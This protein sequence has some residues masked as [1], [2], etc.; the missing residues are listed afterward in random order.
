MKLLSEAEFAELRIGAELIESDGH[1]EKVLR[2]PDGSYIKIFRRKSWFS[3][4]MLIPP[5]RRFAAN[6][7]KLKQLGI[8]CPEVIQLFRLKRPYRSVIHY[9][10][11][12]GTT[13]RQL[14]K[15]QA[16][17]DQQA[18]VTKLASF[19][20]VLHQRGV[21]F[22]SLHLGNIV[23]TP[24]G[25]LGLIDIADMRCIGKPLPTRLQK[26]N[27]QHLFRYAD[28]WPAEQRAQLNQLLGL[29]HA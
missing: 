26:R 28:E 3:K 14:L 8:L 11:L 18:M 20:S 23:M 29:E 2:L 1:G 21:Y 6:T 10:P 13:F 16:S 12:A 17:L 24:S 19:I 9:R 25:E 7:L 4:T 5:A 22:R 15:E 27:M